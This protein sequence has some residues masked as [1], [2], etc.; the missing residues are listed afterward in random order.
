[1]GKRYLLSVSVLV[2]KI[3]CYAQPT[4]SAYSEA[5]KKQARETAEMNRHYNEIKPSQN[6]SGGTLSGD[7]NSYG[8]KDDS[9]MKGINE[10]EAKQKALSDAF[11]A[12]EEKL[13]KILAEY[14]IMKHKNFYPQVISASLMAGFDQ[15][16]AVRTFG[17]NA[18]EFESF[19]GNPAYSL[20]KYF[21][22]GAPVSPNV[23]SSNNAAVT[24]KE[25]NPTPTRSTQAVTGSASHPISFAHVSET[26]KKNGYKQFD[27]IKGM[28]EAIIAAGGNNYDN[29]IDK[30]TRYEND[31][32]KCDV[33]YGLKY[34]WRNYTAPEYGIFKSEFWKY[35]FIRYYIHVES[36]EEAKTVFDE[37]VREFA[38][39]GRYKRK[40]DKY[41]DD[42]TNAVFEY[43]TNDGF[44]YSAWVELKNF[45]SKEAFAIRIGIDK[46]DAPV[47]AEKNEPVN[48]QAAGKADPV[49]GN[50]IVNEKA[51][52]EKTEPNIPVNAAAGNVAGKRPEPEN[53]TG[54]LQDINKYFET[55]DNGYYGNVEI[56]DGYLVIYF[57]S[58]NYSKIKMD[59]LQ[60]AI[61]QPEYQRVILQCKDGGKCVYS[62]FNK[63]QKYEYMQ[64]TSNIAFDRPYLVTL[65]N[66]LIRLY[67]K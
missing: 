36:K 54:A 57:R 40:Q 27:N 22:A 3:Y 50:K 47:A 44:R 66:N 63:G 33:V 16:W 7:Y 39:S 17:N 53:L 49:A 26:Q 42:A 58:G 67:K 43:S 41:I 4:G 59:D 38:G 52:A 29:I 2:L 6:S 23:P 12:K 35:P 10:A 14:G 51:K 55:F 62:T 21:G 30:T 37:F 31:E 15:Y 28:V 20:H 8:M 5:Q 18:G 34:Y 11:T 9:K 24:K 45:R 64:F 48:D 60:G 13:K 19:L 1:M 32:C 61:E 25:T 65:L 46:K 56:K